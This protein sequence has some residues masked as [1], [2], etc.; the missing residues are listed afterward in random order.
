MATGAKDAMPFGATPSEETS[1]ILP[2]HV[3]SHGDEAPPDIPTG[4]TVS[5]RTSDRS[6]DRANERKRPNGRLHGDQP[7]RG[8]G[9]IE[10]IAERG[11]EIRKPQSSPR[12]VRTSR[13]GYM[14]A[15]LPYF[16]VPTMFLGAIQ[17]LYHNNTHQL[18]L[19]PELFPSVQLHSGVRQGCPL[20]PLLL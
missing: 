9:G 14:W 13:G 10:T 12:P 5:K 4:V 19:G 2:I 1:L 15:I 18:V 8:A 11:C 7:T 16:G 20:S 6:N 17:K 3:A